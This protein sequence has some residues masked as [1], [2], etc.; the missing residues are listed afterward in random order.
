M[1]DIEITKKLKENLLLR[2]GDIVERVILFGSRSRGTALPD[3]DYDLLVVLK[4]DYD[5]RLANS[6]LDACY[7]LDVQYDLLTDIKLI[8]R[9]ELNS[10]KGSQPFIMHA[11]AEGVAV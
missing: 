1:T 10:I 11:F 3:S 5:W 2:F 6:I 8:S 4:I 9:A 7:E